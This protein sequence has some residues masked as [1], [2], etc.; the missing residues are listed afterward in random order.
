LTERASRSRS[1]VPVLLVGAAVLGAVLLLVLRMRMEPPTVPEYVLGGDG[2]A[3]VLHRGERFRFD[4]DPMG[5][6]VG[7][8]GARGFL[9]RGDE[10]RPWDPPFQVARDGSVHLAG[11]VDTLF[12]GVPP[13][14][15]EL[16][17][18]VGRPENLPTAPRDI[19]RAREGS[20]AQA[21]WRLV[22]E[23]IILGG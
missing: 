18:A 6:V 19:L 13:G 20:P 16:A 2:G 1:I 22:R 5:Q 17:V 7:A 4:V 12:Q 23:S 11:P 10:V 21:A 3:I 14:T 8:I 9:L 15:W